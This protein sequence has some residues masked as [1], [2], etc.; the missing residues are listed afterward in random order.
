MTTTG[1]EVQDGAMRIVASSTSTNLATN[2]RRK[3]FTRQPKLQQMET[4]AT[5]VVTILIS[6]LIA[7]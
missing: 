7:K 2:S 1:S 5:L 3:F 6:L 4:L